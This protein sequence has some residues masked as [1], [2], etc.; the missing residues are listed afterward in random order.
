[1]GVAYSG[2]SSDATDTM[3]MMSILQNKRSQFEAK[4]E[5]KRGYA[6]PFEVQG[7]RS[8]MRQS[9]IRVK[10]GD[11]SVTDALSVALNDFFA[12]VGGG[13][14]KQASILGAIKM[15]TSGLSAIFSVGEG[16]GMEKEDFI[17]IF[18]N[19]AFVRVDFI[20]YCFCN[21]GKSWNE[22]KSEAGACYVADLAVLDPAHLTASEM[23]FF[24]S[25]ALCMTP[26]ITIQKQQAFAA[27]ATAVASPAA[28][29]AAGA[30]AA[31]SGTTV[32]NDEQ[33]KVKQ[34]RSDVSKP[35]TAAPDKQQEKLLKMQK[36]VELICRMKIL[37]VQ[38]SLLSG[39]LSRS[40]NITF[41]EMDEVTKAMTTSMS[42]IKKLYD[43][44]EP[45]EAPALAPSDSSH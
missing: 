37:L 21:K 13:N 18:C 25:Q 44:L 27:I 42:E 14:V 39:M 33:P 36:D 41:K 20:A 19:Y 15:L 43:D 24:L 17:V 16:T 45:F 9:E 4:I 34:Q 23:D 35:V 7:G 32:K 11:V 28:V 6:S 3:Q 30:A 29:G 22:P 12:A 1:M 31:A 40:H 26:E 8:V 5:S 10:S 38:S 2:S